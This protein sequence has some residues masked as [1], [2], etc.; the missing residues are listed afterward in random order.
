LFGWFDC[1]VFGGLVV[2]VVLDWLFRWFGWFVNLVDLVGLA[3]WLIAGLELSVLP[4]HMYSSLLTNF[5]LTMMLIGHWQPDPLS[6]EEQATRK[7][8]EE[9]AAKQAAAQK[10]GKKKDRKGMMTIVPWLNEHA[11][12]NFF[13][14][15]FF[16][17][18]LL[19]LD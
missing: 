4:R 10:K 2:L 3:V 14:F 9:Q 11:P 17:W 5:K 18:V 8:Q 12:G 15:T 16:L 7:E 13:F 19:L 6:A 1:L